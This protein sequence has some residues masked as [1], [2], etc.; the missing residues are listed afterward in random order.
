[1]NFI[2]IH[3]RDQKL[4]CFWS[5]FVAHFI[6]NSVGRLTSSEGYFLRG[7][8]SIPCWSICRLEHINFSWWSDMLSKLNFKKNAYD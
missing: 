8:Q 2:T 7:Q 1:M 4:K 5:F 6:Y 3:L